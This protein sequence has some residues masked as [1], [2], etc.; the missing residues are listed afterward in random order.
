MH[1]WT[2][3]QAPD[4]LNC[5]YHHPQREKHL[6][7]RS[8]G[9]NISQSFESRKHSRHVQ[10]RARSTLLTPARPRLP[11]LFALRASTG[12]ISMG[13]KEIAGENAASSEP[14]NHH[15]RPRQ[16]L[17]DSWRDAAYANYIQKWNIKTNQ[18]A[19]PQRTIHKLEGTQWDW[20][21]KGNLRS[22]Q[23]QVDACLDHIPSPRL[24]QLFEPSS[25]EREASW[26]QKQR[27]KY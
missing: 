10:I 6:E 9:V 20:R 3:S 14:P 25:L 7:S 4:C 21:A 22:P 24:P 1:A 18:L 15:C 23:P 11:Q 5:S 19:Q 16:G 13:A 8:K 2:P 17:S 26:I 27:R 12:I